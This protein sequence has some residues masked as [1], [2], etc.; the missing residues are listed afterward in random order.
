MPLAE[1][2]VMYER[3]PVSVLGQ[4]NGVAVEETQPGA[5]GSADVGLIGTVDRE[6]S[7]V[8]TGQTGP[9]A[10]MNL[11]AHR[12]IGQSPYR[13]AVVVRIPAAP[14]GTLRSREQVRSVDRVVLRERLIAEQGRADPNH[15]DSL[16]AATG[17]AGADGLERDLVR[18]NMQWPEVG[19]DIDQ[20]GMAGWRS[21][22]Q[23]GL[24]PFGRMIISTRLPL[25]VP[26][27]PR[28]VCRRPSLRPPG[29]ALEPPPAARPAADA[30]PG[31]EALRR[32]QK[33]GSPCEAWTKGALKLRGRDSR[34][35]AKASR[36]PEIH[37]RPLT[38]A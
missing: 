10:L 24:S 32:L 31:Q 17:L 36:A 6:A 30:I 27:L 3:Q 1:V 33:H 23:P 16:G 13:I 18:P 21:T 20:R 8:A 28:A 4:Q 14:G 22:P 15:L 19:A 9:V 2:V 26:R 34:T 37:W 7:A 11:E 5:T 35:P 38:G 25:P 29:A 12:P